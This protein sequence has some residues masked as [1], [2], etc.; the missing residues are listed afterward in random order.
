MNGSLFPIKSFLSNF[1][2][3][4]PKVT[5]SLLLVTSSVMMVQIPAP[6]LC[7][8]FKTLVQLLLGADTKDAIEVSTFPIISWSDNFLLTSWSEVSQS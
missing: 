7:L 5:I 1:L 8:L 2:A 3:P 4:N 6:F